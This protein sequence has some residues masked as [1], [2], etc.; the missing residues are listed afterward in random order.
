MNKTGSY[1]KDTLKDLGQKTNSNQHTPDVCKPLSM[2]EASCR[3]S[4]FR[5]QRDLRGENG[6]TQKGV[7]AYKGEPT[8]NKYRKTKKTKG[9]AQANAL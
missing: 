4:T 3:P 6:K 8:R 7:R 5:N 2:A 1:T 9:E